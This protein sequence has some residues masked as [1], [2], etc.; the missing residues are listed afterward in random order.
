[1]LIFNMSNNPE[2]L[3]KRMVTEWTLIDHKLQI[4]SCKC[5]NSGREIP[6][7][8]FSI[9]HFPFHKPGLFKFFKIIATQNSI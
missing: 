5:D 4:P 8:K 9:L 6:L 3:F 2:I 1:M 7:L